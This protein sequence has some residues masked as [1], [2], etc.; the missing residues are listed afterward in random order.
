MEIQYVMTSL[1]LSL[2]LLKTSDANNLRGPQ[3]TP[4]FEFINLSNAWN[5]FPLF[6]GPAW[7]II[8][9]VIALAEG[10]LK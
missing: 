10:Y 4:D 2:H 3:Y 5:V 1:T 6:V 9:L 8:F 7:K